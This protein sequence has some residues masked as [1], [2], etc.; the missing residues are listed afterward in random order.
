MTTLYLTRHGQTV[1]NFEKRFQGQLGSPLTE[2]GVKQAQWL[3]DRLKSVEF[4]AIY[5]SPLSRAYNTA[6]IVKGDRDLRIIKDDRLKEMHFG[7]WEGKKAEEI[8]KNHK[9]MFHNLWNNPTE[10]V[11]NNGESYKE[12]YDRIIPV[13]EE[14][15]NKHDGNVLI[16]A[17]GIVLAIIMLY[18]KGR[19]LKDLWEDTVLPNTSLTIVEAENDKFNIKLYG[20]VSHHK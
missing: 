13:I 17:H 15:K 12:L 10:Y 11:S 1:W 19:P 5:S 20:D 2:M 4:Q 18:V 8:N 3:R 7:D 9:E 16:V 6:S 14:I